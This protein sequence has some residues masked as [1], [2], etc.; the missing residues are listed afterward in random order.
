M[1]RS[2]GFGP[3]IGAH[4]AMSKRHRKKRRRRRRNRSDA[5]TGKAPPLPNAK[6][7]RTRSPRRISKV[8]TAI[9]I[10]KYRK[11]RA[12]ESIRVEDIAREAGCSVQNLYKSPE[13]K[14]DLEAA[15][16]TRIRRGWK[17]EGVADCPDD[18]T[19]DEAES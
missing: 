16:K 1:P 18:S 10:L 19:L 2:A 12:R 5:L 14:K 4:H 15:R 3:F 13:F 11:K 8:Q 17:N 9:V 7:K 6:P